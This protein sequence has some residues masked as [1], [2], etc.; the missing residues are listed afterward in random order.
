MEINEILLSICIP[1]YNRSEILNGNLSRIHNQIKGKNLPI[2]IIVSDNCSA[3]NTAD[4]VQA[5]ISE[6]MPINYIRN[7]ENLGMDGNFAQ[8]YRRASGKYILVLGDDDYLRKGKLEKLL[9]YLSKGEYGL[10]HLKV[11]SNSTEDI[12]VF[13]SSEEF[14]KNISF[15]ITYITSN[16][17]NSKYVIGHDF[18]K[19][20]GTYLTIVPLYLTSATSKDKNL[21]IYD[22]IFEDGKD[23][24]TNGGYNFFEVFVTNYLSIWKQYARKNKI[25][26]ILY[27]YIKYDIF[28]KY[29]VDRVIILLILKQKGNFKTKSG[30]K[31]L[32]YNYG[33]CPYFYSSLIHLLCKIFFSRIKRI[34]K[35]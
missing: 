4:I 3:D 25:T 18:E 1:T 16:I 26:N 27:S 33:Y 34:F 30:W 20:F 12:Q 13:D 28:K 9:D 10:V 8:C 14:L 29:V 6:G 15:W 17:V 22:R 11:A 5:H 19:Y 23:S 31:I 21:L 32:M 2:E 35:I 24:K 7:N